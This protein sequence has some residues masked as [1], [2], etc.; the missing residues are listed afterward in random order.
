MTAVVAISKN[1]FTPYGAARNAFY[2]K[3]PELI[4]SGPYDTGKTITLLQKLN[5]LMCLFG[6]ARALMIRKTYASLKTSAVVT[7]DKKVHHNRFEE[8]AARYPIKK[9]GG[10]NPQAYTY[11]NGSRIVLGGMDKPGKTLSTEYDFVYVNQ[12][13]E[14][15]EDEWQVL[16]RAASGRSGNA[17]YTQ[18]MGDCNPDVPG[19]WIQKRGRLELHESRHEENPTIFDQETGELIAPQRMAT[20]DA[21]TGVRYKR[22]RLGLWV[23]REGQVYEFDPAVH[24]INRADLP[25]MKYWY[26]SID[27]GYVNPFVCQIWGEDGDGR[28][29]LTREIYM[30]GRTVS[31]HLPAIHRISGRRTFQ[32]TITD[33]D[34]EDR[35]TLEHGVRDRDGRLVV[36]GIGYTI[37]AEKAVTD[38]IQKVED[39]MRVQADG[40]PRLF[41]VRDAI[42]EIDHELDNGNRPTSTQAEFPGYVWPETKAGRAKEERPIKADDHGM[43]AMRY[44]VMHVDKAAAKPGSTSYA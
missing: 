35:A 2:S 1:G 6:G 17:T 9:L 11:P 24:L 4:L 10:E 36:A 7:W 38:G 27:F 13:E 31:D 39:R 16:T 15:T 21:M 12:A 5:L 22:G 8:D 14:L 30:S 28:L 44:L 29:Y 23:G 18:V 41:I 20:L 26:R 37:P 3:A 34:A 40:K 42:Y 43:D 32:A 19:H 25:D 33:H